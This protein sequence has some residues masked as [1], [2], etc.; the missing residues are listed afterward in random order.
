MQ[1]LH[2]AAVFLGAGAH[3]LVG[4]DGTRDKA[5]L[6]PAYDDSRGVTAAFNRNLL[7]RINREL[8]AEFDPQ[9]FDHQ[10]R[11]DPQR[12]RVEMHLASRVRQTV[13]LQGRVFDFESGETI[14]T[15]NSYKYPV[16]MFQQLA[17]SAGWRS[18]NHWLAEGVDY[19]VHALVC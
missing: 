10:A 12:G 6:L 3:L 19:A 4:V 16:A 2:G 9:A 7:V 17:H 5:R 11:F 8:G 13:R 14:H 15:E 18:Q 1:F